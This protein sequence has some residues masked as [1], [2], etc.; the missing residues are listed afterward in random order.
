MAKITGPL[1][2]ESAHGKLAQSLIYSKRKEGNI[3]RGFHMPNKTISLKQ[4]TQRHII[5]LLTAHWQV[6]STVEKLVYENL[7]A[8][9][10]LNI[11]GFNYFIKAAKADLYTHHGLCG[12]WSMNESTGAQ[13]TD[14]SGQNN[15]GT[16]LP[17][18]PSNCPARVTAMNTQ[19]G[20]ALSFDGINDF[21]G[22]PA[23]LSLKPSDITVEFWMNTSEVTTDSSW[24]GVIRGA[25]GSGYYD[26]W[27]VLDISNRPRLSMN[28]GDAD[29]KVINGGLLSINKWYHVVGTYNH[30]YLRLYLNG[31]STGTPLAETRNINWGG[32]D[33]LAIGLAGFYFYGFID[34]VRIYNRAL[35]VDEIKK[36]YNLL[37]LD[38]K[39]QPLLIH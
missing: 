1:M 35:G 20:N 25:Y 11:S 6:K 26:G 2:S 8:T 7:A 31:V 22:V 30:Q 38:K 29:P 14:Y 9:S 4:W 12:Y 19:Y 3:S 18:Y 23:S 5:G 13:V 39:R 36:H 24:N 33:I 28:F 10:G 16:L 27:R 37:R 17:L 32:T 21:V 15:N 34:E